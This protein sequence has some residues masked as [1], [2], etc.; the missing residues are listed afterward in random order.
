VVDNPG[1]GLIDYYI[2]Y[3]TKPGGAASLTYSYSLSTREG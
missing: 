1:A 3:P 2:S